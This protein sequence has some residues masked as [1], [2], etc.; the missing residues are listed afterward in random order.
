MSKLL[1]SLPLCSVCG[2]DLTTEKDAKRQLHVTCA[3]KMGA[4]PYR[5]EA[6][7]HTLDGDHHPDSM[8]VGAK[9]EDEAKDFA[10]SIMSNRR[11]VERVTITKVEAQ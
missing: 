5:V 6:T 2:E 4:M 11:T 9:D 10:A 7:I 3:K 1:D 8:T